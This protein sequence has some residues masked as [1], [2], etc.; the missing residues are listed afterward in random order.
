MSDT[1]SSLSAWQW[2]L[3]GVGG[4]CALVALMFCVFSAVVY[5][6]WLIDFKKRFN[7]SDP[8]SPEFRGPLGLA[9]KPT[10]IPR[11]VAQVNIQPADRRPPEALE[12]GV[13]LRAARNRDT[14]MGWRMHEIREAISKGSDT[15][16]VP[17]VM[18]TVGTVAVAALRTEEVIDGLL[19]TDPEAARA[20]AAEDGSGET[21]W[22]VLRARIRMRIARSQLPPPA[23]A[24]H[25][26]MDNI[27]LSYC[28][29]LSGWIFVGVPAF[30]HLYHGAFKILIRAWLAGEGAKS[31]GGS[32]PTD[33][34]L[35]SSSR[36]ASN[37]SRSRR[38]AL[39]SDMQTSADTH[40]PNP[41]LLTGGMYFKGR[42]FCC[43][44][45]GCC[46]LPSILLRGLGC[47]CCIP[48]LLCRCCLATRP[49]PCRLHGPAF[50]HSMDLRAEGTREIGAA[51]Q[52]G[53]KR[54]VG[55]L[56]LEGLQVVRYRPGPQ[57]ADGM[58]TDG[59]VP[60]QPGDDEV[61]PG[62]THKVTFDFFGFACLNKENTMVVNE[63]L[64]VRT[65]TPYHVCTIHHLAPPSVRMLSLCLRAPLRWFWASPASAWHALR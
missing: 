15:L 35:A 33:T 1:L 59:K 39:L 44:F 16:Q 12:A 28:Q 56:L 48:R 18:P 11:S 64:E 65:Y 63:D 20:A 29:F 43:C 9:A 21:W 62:D 50:G 36:L 61:Q 34:R 7:R 38:V 58:A 22:G 3:I 60:V 41:P 40:C 10:L 47:L 23:A 27:E 8:R 45:P 32:K 55:Q 25:L 52:L 57:G 49:L 42:A 17:A 6:W 4:A 24:R 5:R 13:E 51:E 37:S 31:T 54:L 46:C 19:A 14:R 26:D 2:A 30:I 53:Y